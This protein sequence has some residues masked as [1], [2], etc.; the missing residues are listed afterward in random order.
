MDISVIK[1]AELTLDEAAEI[2]GVSAVMMWKYSKGATPRKNT[3][4]PDI[5]ARLAMLLYVLE[6]L[7]E[8]G[9]LPKPDLRVT[10]RTHPEI[11]ARRVAVVERLKQLVDTRLAAV[12]ANE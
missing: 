6:R 1:T 12:S 2:V 5:G 4:G 11:K 7:I 3:K 8:K 9:A 10:T